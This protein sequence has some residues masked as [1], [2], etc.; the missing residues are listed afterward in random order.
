MLTKTEIGTYEALESEAQ[1]EEEG[2]KN[3]PTCSRGGCS[4]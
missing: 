3:A 4:L 1:E 2:G